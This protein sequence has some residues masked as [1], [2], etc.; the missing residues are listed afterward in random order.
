MKKCVLCSSI[1]SLTIPALVGIVLFNKKTNSKIKFENDNL[2]CL[3]LTPEEI[4][5]E[6]SLT[7]NAS[8]RI[9]LNYDMFSYPDYENLLTSS[10]GL[11]KN[12]LLTAGRNYYYNHN[13]SLLELMDTTLM[14]NIYISKYSPFI[15]FEC[16]NA[17]LENIYKNCLT[18]LDEKDFVSNI[19]VKS[20]SNFSYR[21]NLITAKNVKGVTAAN[22]SGLTGQGIKVGILEPGILDKN[23]TNFTG[24]N[25]TVCDDLFINE[26]VAEH[27]TKMGSVIGGR[28]GVAPNCSLYSVQL[29]G[30]AIQEID[31]LLDRGV[32][33]INMSYGEASPTGYYNDDSAYMDFIVNTYKVAI[34]AAAGNQGDSDKYVCNPGLGYNVFT[35]GGCNS[36]ADSL[37]YYLVSSSLEQSGP[38]KPNLLA[39]ASLSVPNFTFDHSGTSFSSAFTTGCVA[40]MMEKSPSLKLHP[41]RVYAILSANN[42]SFSRIN[43]VGLDEQKGAGAINMTKVI[44]NIEDIVFFTTNSTNH[45]SEEIELEVIHNDM[46]KAS[47]WWL[48]YADGIAEHTRH[49]NFDMALYDDLLNRKA[50]SNSGKN[51]NEYFQEIITEAGWY[52]INFY[53]QG[54]ENVQ[55]DS[56]CVAFNIEEG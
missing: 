21:E 22:N 47:A 28:F 3:S 41:E 49:S 50:R 5:D 29:T 15:T 7:D 35:L 30:D 16:Q 42:D 2:K 39:P 17:E 20:Q 11:F 44:N 27:T 34:I 6:I 54:Q 48:A 37:S 14:Q 1:I 8:I 52:T 9:K 26:T 12:E 38:D 56:Y 51:N 36:S 24:K 43:Y 18:S 13:V 40:L 53:L 31:W 55:F 46:I 10:I 25:V 4:E 23:H 45:G 19:R 32:D 33:I